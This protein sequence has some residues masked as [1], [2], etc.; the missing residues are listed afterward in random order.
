MPAP[1][2]RSAMNGAAVRA[3]PEILASLIVDSLEVRVESG[4]LDL[5]IRI[6][7]GDAGE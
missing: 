4:R 5:R 6:E 1:I 7:A 3:M 2:A